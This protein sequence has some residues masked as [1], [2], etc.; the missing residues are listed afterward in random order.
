[1]VEPPRKLAVI[2][3][4]YVGLNLAMVAV[5]AGY[6]VVGVDLDRSRVERLQRGM[7][8][9]RSSTSSRCS[10]GSSASTRGR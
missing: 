5:E 6:D 2:G 7:S 1:M 4:G 10:R 9:S 8:T 3:Q